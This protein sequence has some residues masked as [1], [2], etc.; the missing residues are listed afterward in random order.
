MKLVN[1]QQPQETCGE[2]NFT[3][4]SLRWP[5]ARCRLPDFHHQRAWICFCCAPC[6]DDCCFVACS[7]EIVWPHASSSAIAAATCLLLGSQFSSCFLVKKLLFP[8]RILSWVVGWMAHCRFEREAPLCVSFCSAFCSVQD[9][10]VL[11]FVVGA[12]CDGDVC[13]LRRW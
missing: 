6:D 2:I 5:F 13:I 11:A 8:I 10:Y 1:E 7:R 4:S 9:V 3:F 12:R